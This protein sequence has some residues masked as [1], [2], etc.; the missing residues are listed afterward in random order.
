[1]ISGWGTSLS[2]S[3]LILAEIR[4]IVRSVVPSG[5][6]SHRY[7]IDRI[8]AIRQPPL[9]YGRLTGRLRDL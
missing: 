7:V 1:M 5:R 4:G 6:D 2:A 9:N 3:A 8:S